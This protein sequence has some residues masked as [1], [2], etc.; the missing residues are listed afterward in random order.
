M[1]DGPE[2]Q[3]GVGQWY[4]VRG[5]EGEWLGCAVHVGSNFVE[6]EGTGGGSVR[7]HVDDFDET[8]RREKRPEAVID[9]QVAFHQGNVNG[10]LGRVKEIT[11][12]L[13]ITQGPLLGGNETKA[14]A[15]RGQ[16][17]DMREY[18]K[19]LVVAKEK[20]LPDLFKEI[21]VEHRRLAEWM[22]AKTIPV[23]AMAKRMKHVVKAIDDRIFSVELYAGLTEE[24]TRVRDGKPAGVTEKI[25]LMQRRSYMDEECLA[26]YEAG[27]MDFNDISEFDEWLARKENLDRLLP[28]ARSVTSFRVRRIAKEREVVTFRDFVRV[29]FE[30]DLDKATF[31]YVRNGEQLFRI[32]TAL[33]FGEKLFPDMDRGRLSGKLWAKKWG[34]KIDQVIGENEHQ[35]IVEDDRRREEEARKKKESLPKEEHWRVGY[36]SRESDDYV[37]FDRSTVYYDDISEKLEEEIKQ[38]NRIALVLQ[39]LLDRSPVFHPHPAWQIGTPEGFGQA[40][41]LV[42]DESRALVAGDAPDFEEFRAKLNESIKVG[43]VTIG[44]QVTWEEHEAEKESKRMDE[45]GV[46]SDWRPTRYKPRGNPG[47]GDVARVTRRGKGSCTYEWVRER[48]MG[49]GDGILV[50]FTTEDRN[51]LNAD[52]YSP[53]DFRRFFDDP[54]TRAD[55]LQWAPLLLAAE[56]YR[57]GNRAVQEPPTKRPQRKE[58]SWDG[59]RRYAMRKRRKELMGKAVRLT[60]AVETKGGSKYAVGSLWRVVEGAGRFF[61]IRG[62]DEA[63]RRDDRLVRTIGEAYFEEVDGVPDE[64]SVPPKQDGGSPDE[65]GEEGGDK[66]GSGAPHE[67]AHGEADGED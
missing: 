63:G 1:M 49:E 12:S 6:V 25:H 67:E 66:E 52:A 31:L 55:Y 48:L 22:V 28:F 56:E 35:G 62:I 60:R 30:R 24:V 18:G 17:Q 46:R 19:A 8:C 57:A 10:L 53:G 15:V 64:K 32:Q 7:I 11:A 33:D 42:Y 16:N 50:S 65:G 34:F 40:L 4:W 14:L 23:K 21:E 37:P 41:T 36:V 39:G 58:P 5:K 26:R 61:T 44:Q 2:D 38:H 3:V 43:S 47:P 51:V 59:Q 54:R 9:A 13:A 27:G 45:A 20:D 29:S